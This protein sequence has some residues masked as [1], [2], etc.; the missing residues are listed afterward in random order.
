MVFNLIEKHRSL[1]D[2][3]VVDRSTRRYEGRPMIWR[4]GS[5]RPCGMRHD[6]GALIRFPEIVEQPAD[7]DCNECEDSRDGSRMADAILRGLLLFYHD[8]EQGDL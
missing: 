1:H 6:V 2:E 3:P 8:Q 4:R 7:P 5:R